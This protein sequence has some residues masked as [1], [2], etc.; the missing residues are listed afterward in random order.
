MTIQMRRRLGDGQPSPLAYSGAVQSILNGLKAKPFLSVLLLGLALLL[1]GSWILPLLD[2][3]EPRFAEAS[4]EM[5]QR[6][7]PVIPRLNGQYR[8]DKP[9]LI[10]WCQMGCYQLLGDTSFAARLPGALFATGTAL[11]LLLWGRRL[12]N[13]RAGLYAALIFITCLQVLVHGRLSVADMPMVFF[14]TAAVWSGWELARP[15]AC[16][17]Q[18]WWWIFYASLALGFLAK[19]PVAWLPLGGLFWSRWRRPQAFQIAWGW[20]FAGLVLTLALVAVWGLPALLQ[21]QGEYF[22]VGIG[23]H[24]VHRSFGIMEGH[25]AGGWVGFA[26]TLPFYFITFFLSFF[27][28]SLKM[29]RAWRQWRHSEPPDLL[30]WYLLVQ[31]ALVFLTFTLV[32]TKLPHYTLPAFPCLSLWLAFRLANVRESETFLTRGVVGMSALALVLTLGLFSLAAPHFAASNLWRQVRPHARPEMK[33]ASVKMDEPSLVWE[34]R[35]GI[36]NY[37]EWLAPSE[38]TAFLEQP[39]P[40]VL[41]LPSELVQGRIKELATNAI[42][43]QA[44]GIDS[45][46][47]KRWNLTAIIRPAPAPK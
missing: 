37:M 38:A 24:V 4:R 23:R 28:W 14:F 45:V 12:G 11:L 15:S 47:F 40:R 3:D 8:F 5:L 18:R 30:G 43:V 39:T 46:H 42:V 29:P 27:P 32:M 35:H 31:S 21:T 6:R 17:S 9:P 19:G 2:R 41:V 22:S 34:F 44:A 10:Y 16:G 13:A 1:S 7:D 25:G 20:L 36:T 33:M 26:L